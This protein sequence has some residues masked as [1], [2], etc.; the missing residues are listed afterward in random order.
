MTVVATAAAPG[1]GR[2][3]LDLPVPDG[4]EAPKS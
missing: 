4:G 3:D 2:A 1:S